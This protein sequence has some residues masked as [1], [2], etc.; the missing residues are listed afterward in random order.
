M[1]STAEEAYSGEERAHLLQVALAAIE[2]GL[3]TDAR[4]SGKPEPLTPALAARRACFVT[5]K[6]KGDLRGCI[7]S[8][9]PVTSLVEDVAN[10]AWSAA[11]RDPRFPALAADE[12]ED[13]EIG[14]SVL[15]PCQTLAFASERELLDGLRPGV[16]GLILQDGRHRGTFLPS[17]WESLPKPEDFLAHLKLKAGLPVDYWSETLE[18][19]RYT[20]TSFA[21]GVPAI[22]QLREEAFSS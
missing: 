9:A 15:G 4:P 22:R 13:L 1:S 11:F 5:L 3:E 14:I 21:A 20:T 18:V 17:V 10:N 7:G 16:D 6:R 8:L 2:A 19:Q 12:L